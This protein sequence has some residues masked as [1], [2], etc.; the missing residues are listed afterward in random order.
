MA[1]SN[2]IGTSTWNYKTRQADFSSVH[3]AL[4]LI[5]SMKTHGFTEIQLYYR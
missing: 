4:I 3:S 1:T 2:M 5:W